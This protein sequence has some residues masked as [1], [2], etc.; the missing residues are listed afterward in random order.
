MTYAWAVL[1]KR[2]V[3]TQAMVKHSCERT[4]IAVNS[5]SKRCRQEPFSVLRW[6]A[7]NMRASRRQKLEQWPYR[8]A[9]LMTNTCL[10]AM[11]T[12]TNQISEV[13]VQGMKTA[14]I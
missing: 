4:L 6:I 10:D 9:N 2:I 14:V 5:R 12:V 11:G 7:I 1:L 3:A 13:S 8:N